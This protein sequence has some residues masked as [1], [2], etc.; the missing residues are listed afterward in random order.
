M[1]KRIEP[2]SKDWYQKAYAACFFASDP[3]E[4]QKTNPW[5]EAQ[6]NYRYHLGYQE[7]GFIIIDDHSDYGEIL[8][9]GVIPQYRQQ[10]IAD[11]ILKQTLQDFS[12][13]QYCLLEVSKN[14]LAALSLYKK[15]GFKEIHQRK[16]YYRAKL[17]IDSTAIVM[18]RCKL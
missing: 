8:S 2:V 16:N 13:W 15:H 1:L 10:G 7:K 14:N 18:Q 6:Y 3:K 5:I 12:Q 4:D 11:S 17:E 9:L